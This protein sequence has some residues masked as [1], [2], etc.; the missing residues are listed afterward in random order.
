MKKWVVQVNNSFCCL[1]S[2]HYIGML[3]QYIFSLKV[4]LNYI[5]MLDQYIFSLKVILNSEEHFLTS[6]KNLMSNVE[7]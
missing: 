4:I 6:T 5:G 1:V 3:D 2:R 7:N